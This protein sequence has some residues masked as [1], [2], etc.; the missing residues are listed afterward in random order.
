MASSP[1][2]EACPTAFTSAPA[3]T[4]PGRAAASRPSSPDCAGVPCRSRW[5]AAVHGRSALSPTAA[6][7]AWPWRQAWRRA[8]FE[9]TRCSGDQLLFL[10]EGAEAE[11]GLQGGLQLA[12]AGD[13][14][15]TVVAGARHRLQRSEEHTSELQ[16][17]MRIS[18]SVFCLKKNTPHYSL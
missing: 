7:S 4:A 16:S 15:L 1:R 6:T 9:A 17:L 10:G 14:E 3:T 2:P 11:P 13:L 5:S 18:Y 12:A 8:F